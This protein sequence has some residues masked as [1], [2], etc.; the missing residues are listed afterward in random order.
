MNFAWHY[1]DPK[2]QS[3]CNCFPRLGISAM[4]INFDNPDILGQGFSLSAFVE[5][6]IPLGEN[7]NIS[8]RFLAGA[9]YLNNVY[10]PV[11]NPENLFY[12]TNFSYLLSINP[13][14][15]FQ[16]FK[17]W[18]FRIG[19]NY[20][21]ISNGGNTHPNKGI[22][23]P[24]VSIGLDYSVKPPDF[25]RK[26]KTELT[27]SRDKNSFRFILLGTA[28]L[29]FGEQRKRKILYGSSFIY[30]HGISRL[31]RLT[32][33]LEYV[34]DGALKTELQKV[35]GN[36]PDHQ[37]FSALAGHDLVIGRFIFSQQLGVYIYSPV[38][39]M[40]PVFQRWGLDYY[41]SEKFFI[42]T[43]L[44][45]HRHVADFLDFRIGYML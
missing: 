30:G 16:I 21:H 1:S 13:I 18:N 11:S 39:P 15:N 4:Y 32:V 5:P 23:F 6:F 17:N 38:K 36:I 33:G 3:Y 43:N 14:L 25:S 41:I 42:G 19:G 12:S 28:K 45:A 10:N 20:N 8:F 34:N 35:D 44:K 40:D 22:N 7:I 29:P 2:S 27:Q 31:S 24:T 9:V 37:R 26:L